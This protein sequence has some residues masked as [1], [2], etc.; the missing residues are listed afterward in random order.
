ML[1]GAGLRP[2]RWF[3]AL[4]VL[5]VLLASL[6]LAASQAQD[7]VPYSELTGF[8]VLPADTFAPGPPSGFAIAGDY[9][10]RTPPFASQP[11]QGIS[12]VLPQRDDRYLV[13]S[14]NG[15]G[16]KA[17]SPDYRLR[18]YDV[19]PNFDS[20]AVDIIGYTELRDPNSVIPWPIMNQGLDRVLTGADFDLESF[21]QA[22]DGT[23]WF[24]EEFGPFL[25]HTD[26]TGRLLS[27]PISTP[28][29]DELAP[30]SR[31][32]PY[33]QA[34][35]NP[36]FAVL[37]DREAR[38][39]AANL[40]SS[41]GFEGMALN[42]SG[43]KLYPMLE[44]AMFDDPVGNRLLIQ[45]FDLESEQ[46]T[47][48]YW[49]YPRT[50]GAIGAITAINDYEF[51]VIERD[52]AEGEEASFK[53]IY[54][55]NLLDA[56]SSRIVPKELVVDLL[57]IADPRGITS[58]Q[59]GAIGFGPLFSF[60]FVTIESVYPIDEQTLLVIN[61]NNYPFSSGRRP[62]IAPDN[63]EFIRVRLSEVLNLKR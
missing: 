53:R 62:G 14:D 22:P 6:P 16:S 36:A 61:D 4:V 59:P 50:S 8:A 19:Q 31:G 27:Q 29:P 18:W 49:F 32:R 28:Y 1:H 23:F 2:A 5:L 58:P 12:A 25:L 7:D 47:G 26:S 34:P 51:L 56:N 60:P 24:G 20:G 42:A 39:A 30:Y 33:I 44:G 35:E 63:T 15:F 9:F 52:G 11:V 13:L 21:Q 55:I 43:T 38:E 37:P 46:Y 45:E 48:E 54:K 17:N 40:P 41:R 10:G 3:A 57:Q